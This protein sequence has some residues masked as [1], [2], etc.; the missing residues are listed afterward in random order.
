MRRGES[1]EVGQGCGDQVVCLLWTL[2]Q[3]RGSGGLADTVG[4]A[5][6]IFPALHNRPRGTCRAVLTCGS[7]MGDQENRHH[8]HD[9]VSTRT[10]ACFLAGVI[11]LRFAVLSLPRVKTE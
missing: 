6:G 1:Q 10:A 4:T 8:T 7:P 11:F 2:R 9:G 5:A 3:A